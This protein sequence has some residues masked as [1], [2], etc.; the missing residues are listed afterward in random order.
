MPK[1]KKII[2]RIVPIL[3]NFLLTLISLLLILTFS[4]NIAPIK[5]TLVI[6]PPIKPTLVI[7]PPIKP[8]LVIDPPVPDK[9]KLKSIIFTYFYET[10]IM[11]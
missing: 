6:D 10:H 2:S 3:I 11:Y 4:F 7:D 9:C 5:P 1:K 8:T